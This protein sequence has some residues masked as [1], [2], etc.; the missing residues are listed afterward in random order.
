MSRNRGVLMHAHIFPCV[1]CTHSYP[2]CSAENFLQLFADFYFSH[3]TAIYCKHTRIVY[4]KPSYRDMPLNLDEWYSTAAGLGIL[5]TQNMLVH[6][7]MH[8]RW[9]SWSYASRAPMIKARCLFPSPIANCSCSH[10]RIENMILQLPL[11]LVE[12]R[13]IVC[14][15]RDFSNMCEYCVKIESMH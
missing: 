3:S 1:G 14:M 8:L 15:Q 11:L 5:L 2:L 4:A 9:K 6:S 13:I 12:C 10:S 7:I